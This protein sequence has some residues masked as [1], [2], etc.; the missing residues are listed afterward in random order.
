MHIPN[1]TINVGDVLTLGKTKIECLGPLTEYN[2]SSD[3]E[4]QNSLILKFTLGNTSYLSCGDAD[5]S[6]TNQ[7]L[8]NRWGSKLKCSVLH[9]AHHGGGPN[10]SAVMQ[11]ASPQIQVASSGWL[12]SSTNVYSTLNGEFTIILDGNNVR[13]ER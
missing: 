9:L 4:N 13:V 5:G 6:E 10:N 11:N 8:A 12:E 2:H 1:K 7:E 3:K